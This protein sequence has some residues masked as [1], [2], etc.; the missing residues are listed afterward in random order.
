MCRSPLR[1]GF[2]AIL[3]ALALAL[4]A[5]AQS[6]PAQLS[7]PPDGGNM[8]TRPQKAPVALEVFEI[9]IKNFWTVL[10]S[11]KK[12]AVTIQRFQTGS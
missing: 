6:V 3:L 4:F 5:L 12:S 8:T 9:A 10:L 11:A 2:P 7:P 1:R